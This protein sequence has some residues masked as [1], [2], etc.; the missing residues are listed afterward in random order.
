MRAKTTAALL[1]IAACLVA[2]P[3]ASAESQPAWQMQ[4]FP[5]PTN[6]APG[7]E[8]NVFLVAA[9]IGGKPATGAP[10]S[11]TETLPEGLTPLGIDAGVSDSNVPIPNCE[12]PSPRTITCTDVGPINPGRQ[13]TINVPVE[14]SAGAAGILS[15]K[16][17]ISGGGASTVGASGP[18]QVSASPPPFGFLAGAAGFNAPFSQDDGQPATLAGSH[19]Y[20]LTAN[21]GFP[22][23]KVAGGLLE[24]SG[25]LREVSV[26]FPRGVLINPAATPELC[27]E[28]QLISTAGCPLDS[29][30]GALTVIT[31][32]ANPEADTSPVFNMVPP[33]GRPA[34]LGFNALGVGVFIHP[35]GELRSDGDYGITGTVSELP[36]LPLHPAFGSRLEL[37]SDP[38]SPSHDGVRGVCAFGES[39]H[40]SCPL[41]EPPKT[42]TA[43]LALP[44][45]C[46]GKPLRFGARAKSWDEPGAAPKEASY[47]S[48][49]LS[50]S[51]VNVDGCEAL[52]FKPALEAKTTTG[53]TDSPSGL[54]LDVTQPQETKLAGRFTAS[55]KD[56]AITLPEG[57]VVN[58]SAAQGQQACGPAQIGLLTPV[59]QSPARFSKAPASCPDAAKVGTVQVSTPL[60]AQL[61]EAKTKVQ[62]DPDGNPIPRPISGAVYLAQPFQNPFGSLIAVYL[63]VEDPQ[64][65]TVAKLAAQVQAD[66]LTGQ[67]KNVLTEAPELPVA[68]F[69]VHIFGGARGALRT[70]PACAPY[71][72]LAELTPWSG[73]EAT[74]HPSSS[75]ALSGAPGGGACPATAPAA[76]NKPGFV[77]GTISPSAGAFSP[78]VVKISREDA[79]QPLSGFEMTLPPG[80]TARFAAIPYC[81]EAE[82]AQA[83]ARANPNEGAL[84]QANPSCPAASQIGSLD[85]AAGA[86][87]TPL[88][89]TGRVY[90]AGPYKGAPLSAVIITPAIAGPFDLGAVVLRSAI[91]VNPDTAQGRVVSDPL[92]RILDGIPLDLRSATARLDRP[93]FTLNPTSCDPAQVLGAATSVFGQSA[94][95]TS[96]FQVGGCRSLP[97]KPKL[98][99][100]LFGPTHRGGHPRF[101]AVFEAK[102][103]EAN[104]KRIVLALPRS[105]FIDQAHFRTICTRVQFAAGQCPAGSIYGHVK[106]I[107]PLLDFPLEGPVYL[108]SSNQE[109]PDAVAA[110]RGPP[111]QPIEIDGVAHIDAVNGGLRITV[112]TVPDAPITKLIITQQGGKKGLFQN[113]T[114]IC[115]G[116]HRAD[117]K[118]DGQNAKTADAAPAL[119]VSCPHPRKKRKAAGHKR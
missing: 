54:D 33:P 68:D 112:P 30:V 41:P 80:L 69:H 51:P 31:A 5:M 96:P 23:E 109:L 38:A 46:P 85:A 15:A 49:D 99:L 56:A 24:G 25:H 19:P 102:P 87:P 47:E 13:L 6:F 52:E 14:V 43:A 116:T 35:S 4:I 72:T 3:A 101:R 55:L 89:T 77:A 94:A 75:F 62:R 11:V 111:S 21:L 1:G 100:R 22:T 76:P 37:W 113:S 103:G 78:F 8:A 34:S 86:G 7:S 104:T 64:S 65:G 58:P 39:G 53:L 73:A 27:T 2:A 88:H 117:L 63:D 32:V 10:T 40:S 98:H 16:A 92:P 66:P 26:D 61:D 74:A 44:G 82:I 79:S 119:R 114:N 107:S 110:L 108:R 60:L 105:E 67:L 50:G 83:R 28:A 93:R 17:T 97:Y 71:T 36:A 12:E 20:Q 9:N 70:P 18:I 42:E 95:L 59:G 115:K 57:L 91:Y 90:L 81:G 106:A 45:D 84:E 118:L 48:A 29:Q